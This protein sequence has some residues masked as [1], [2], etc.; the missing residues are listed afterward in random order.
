VIVTNQSGIA[1]GLYTPA[2]L[3]TLNT[4]ITAELQAH[5]VQLAGIYACPHHPQAVLPA[6]RVD[7][8][9]RKPQPGLIRQAAREHGLDLGASCLF[10]DKASDIQAGRSAGVG[11]CWLIGDAAAARACGADGAGASLLQAVRASLATQ[12]AS[13]AV[14]RP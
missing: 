5:G 13:Q 8:A 2:D 4:H 1:R 11:Q 14:K 9:C 7:C 3:D 12:P 6:Y 10:G